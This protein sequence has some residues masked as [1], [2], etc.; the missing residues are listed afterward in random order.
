MHNYLHALAWGA[1]NDYIK[2]D[3]RDL[4]SEDTGIA[5]ENLNNITP[6]DIDIDDDVVLIAF[7][8]YLDLDYINRDSSDY[9]DAIDQVSE[10]ARDA[11]LEGIDYD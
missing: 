1:L 8:D 5:P 2:Y 9:Y 3:A 11:L 6:D 10:K 4:V 7:A